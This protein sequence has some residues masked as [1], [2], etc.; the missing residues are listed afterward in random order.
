MEQ[1]KREKLIGLLSNVART[2]TGAAQREALASWCLRH[3]IFEGFDNSNEWWT[4]IWP[5]VQQRTGC[6]SWD[7]IMNRG[8]H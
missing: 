5:A 1:E 7:G 8:K 4:V 2:K 3:A 6:D